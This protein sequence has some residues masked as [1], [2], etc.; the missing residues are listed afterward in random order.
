MKFLEI[1]SILGFVGYAS[2]ACAGAWGQCGGNGF[3]GENC[4]QSG[5][6][7]VKSNEWYS[8]CQ[9]SS[10]ANNNNNN[11]AWAPPANN[12]PWN[13]PTNNNNNPWAP[14]ASQTTQA[15]PAVNTQT[16]QTNGNTG[17]SYPKGTGFQFYTQCKNPKHW[18]MTYDD[19][20]YA[21]HDDIILDILKEKGV[22]ATFFVVGQ[23]YQNLSSA[24]AEKSIKRMY[25]EGHVIGSHTW[26][27]KDLTGLSESEI[28]NEMKQVEDVVYKYIGKKPAFMRPPYGSGNGNQKVMN[29]LKKAG[30]TAAVNWNIDPMDYS[31][32]GDV[33]YA[34]SAFQSKV[35]QPAISLNHLQ[36][37]GSS[38]TGIAALARAEIDVMLNAG[39][40]PVTMEECLGMSAYQ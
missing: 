32:G 9:P 16:P 14:Q 40:K 24:Q 20:P 31:N 3:N 27:H 11:N 7:C 4:C 37:G 23:V 19:G 1:A 17:S 21:P 22:K 33:N 39:Y 28:L 5:Y 13:P 6:A 35:G 38:P 36:Y 12:N 2:A 30:Y 18:A 10:N 8:Q 29:A 25:N 34:K 15:P 26:N